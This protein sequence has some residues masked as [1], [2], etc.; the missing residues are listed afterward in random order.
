LGCT[1]QRFKLTGK[2]PAAAEMNIVIKL[3][4]YWTVLSNNLLIQ[5]FDKKGFIFDKKLQFK[6]KGSSKSAAPC[7]RFL[8]LGMLNHLFEKPDNMFVI[9]RII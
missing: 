5:F 6:S 4:Y 1:I 2:V 8:M 3:I 7:F 9:M